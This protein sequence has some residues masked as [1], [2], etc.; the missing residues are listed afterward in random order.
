MT[1]IEQV[2]RELQSASSCVE[3]EI[4]EIVWS[5][6]GPFARGTEWLATSGMVIAFASLVVAMLAT[7]GA[8]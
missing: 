2:T 8:R 5:T 4:P 7:M 1:T 3:H 6:P